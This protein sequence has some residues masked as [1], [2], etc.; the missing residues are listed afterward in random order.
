METPD[1]LIIGGGIVGGSLARELARAGRTV[2]V[3]ERG[4]VGGAATAASAGLLSPTFFAP[5]TGPLVNLC[6][7]SSAMYESWVAGLR[8]DGAADFGFR[9]T[10]LLSIALKETEAVQI[11][12]SVPDDNFPGRR[13][14]WVSA[15]RLREMEPALA[16]HVLGAAFYPDDAHVD[17]ARLIGQLARV[18]EL[19]GVQLREHEPVRRLELHG[20]RITAVHTS[21]GTYH[22]GLVVLTAGAWTGELAGLVGLA[23]PTRPVK[24]QLLFANCRIPPVKTPLHAGEALLIPWPGGGL[25]LGVTV[26]EAG[27]DAEVRLGSLQRILEQTAALVP[28]VRELPLGRAWAGLRPAS[29]DELPRMGPVPGMANLWV[30]YGH[31]RKGI[32]LAPICA[33]LVAESILA[34]RPVDGLQFYQLAR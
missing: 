20:N 5:L 33:R 26:E 24:G 1:I 25:L 21:H 6:R 28:K 2:T 3:V 10:G 22:P 12:A 14:E 17:P 32:L 8:A 16:P 7:Q 19:A 27:Y 4:S 15:D 31:F 30:S 9:R 23:L 29:A 11:K 18:I 13:A 34:N